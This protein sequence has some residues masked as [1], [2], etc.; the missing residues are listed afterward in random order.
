MRSVLLTFLVCA[1]VYGQASYDLMLIPDAD[2]SVQRFD[3]ISGASLGSFARGSAATAVDYSPTSGNAYIMADPGRIYT[4]NY[5]T[6]IRTFAMGSSTNMEILV[7]DSTSTYGWTYSTGQNYL[8]RYNLTGG[9]VDATLPAGVTS[10]SR[11]LRTSTSRMLAIGSNAA[12]DLVGFTFVPTSNSISSETVTT[13][14][15]SSALLAGQQIGQPARYTGDNY[16]L[17][18]RN[19]TNELRRLNVLINGSGVLY[20]ALSNLVSSSIVAPSG[21]NPNLVP[22]HDGYYAL[23]PSAADP[24]LLSIA[25]FDG[26]TRLMNIMDTSIKV[27]TGSWSAAIV[28]APEP[29]SVAAVSLGLALLFKRR[30]RQRDTTPNLS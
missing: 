15:A 11:L 25:E 14:V 22:A 24:S 18:F 2:G 16:T 7:S 17:L 4:Y 3:P 13:L 5:S 1:G 23:Y 21:I 10:V 9:R 6:G 12:G 27:R 30:N 20:N 28:L 19:N 8:T 29:A 26:T